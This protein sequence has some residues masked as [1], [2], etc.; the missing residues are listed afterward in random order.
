MIQDTISLYIRGN[1]DIINVYN[2]IR[3]IFSKA[4]KKPKSYILGKFEDSRE[5]EVNVVEIQDSFF[6]A[7]E[8]TF[9]KFPPSL[10]LKENEL[11]DM[12]DKREFLKEVDG[13]IDVGIRIL[14]RDDRIKALPQ[15]YFNLVGHSLVGN[16]ERVN[17]PCKIIDISLIHYR[18]D[19]KEC[20][21]FP[22]SY[23]I[24]DLYKF[25]DLCK[26]LN[27]YNPMQSHFSNSRKP[28]YAH[29]VKRKSGK[30]KR[31]NF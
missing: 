19:D 4:S 16:V 2:E 22:Y 24:E 18:T 13:R 8:S 28:Y 7:V 29:R 30:K 15:L 14:S 3:S 1:E 31:W 26:K 27:N 25:I 12:I 21:D 5:I 23:S 17:V 10:L 6:S 20:A 9:N 11:R